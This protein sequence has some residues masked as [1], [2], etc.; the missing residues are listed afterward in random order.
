LV[1][2]ILES[3]ISNKKII[4]SDEYGDASF[5]ILTDSEHFEKTLIVTLHAG[6]EKNNHILISYLQN[7]AFK[8]NYHRIQILTKEILS[9][10]P[11]LEHRISFNLM[12]K[13]LD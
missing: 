2:E 11:N 10:L 7:F 4:Y 12:Q 5:A 9:K 3:L 6:S 1:D 13:S 8:N